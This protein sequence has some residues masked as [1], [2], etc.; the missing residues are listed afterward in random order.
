MDRVYHFSDVNEKGNCYQLVMLMDRE[1]SVM[2]MNWHKLI[3]RI[4][5]TGA[6][7]RHRFSW[8]SFKLNNFSNFCPFATFDSSKCS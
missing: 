7:M 6:Y 3:N 4:T 1:Y 2:Q 5:A 8:A